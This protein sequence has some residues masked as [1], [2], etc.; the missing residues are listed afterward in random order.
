MTYLIDVAIIALLIGTLVYAWVVD[1]RVRG[2]MAALRDLEPMVGSFSAAVDRSESSVSALR[3]MGRGLGAPGASGAAA[4]GADPARS[5][6]TEAKAEAGAPA[7]AKARGVYSMPV[8][9]ELVRGFFETV[10][11]REA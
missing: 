11:S 2:M 7:G 4:T 1:R 8:K 3:S 5:T 6:T 9:S 10:R